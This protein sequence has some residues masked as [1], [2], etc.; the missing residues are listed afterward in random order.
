MTTTVDSILARET[1][2]AACASKSFMGT[3]AD[4]I[5]RYKSAPARL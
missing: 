3:M 1:V 5:G 4:F 2:Y